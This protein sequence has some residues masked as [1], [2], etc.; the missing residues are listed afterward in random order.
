MTFANTEGQVAELLRECDLPEQHPI[1]GLLEVVRHT[2]AMMRLLGY[3]VSELDLE[4]D[5][6][7]HKT[8]DG[9]IKVADDKAIWG[10]NHN[11]D[12]ASHILVS[13][14]GQWSDRYARACKLALDANIDERMV[15]NAEQTSQVVYIAVTRALEA[16]TLTPTQ[17]AA[18][19]KT[20][21]QELRKSLGPLDTIPRSQDAR[22][23]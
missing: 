16:A 14:Y 11:E 23:A 12:Q 13:M 19:S 21:A 2:G 6:S 5:I 3:L 10:L 20:L 15:R 8:E 9:V 22:T 17:A 4:P 18:F 1:D 7:T